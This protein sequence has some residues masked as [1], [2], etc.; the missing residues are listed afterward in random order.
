MAAVGD[1]MPW[2]NGKVPQWFL[3][4]T[5][6]ADDLLET[7]ETMD[8]WP[9]Q[10][11]LMQKNWI[12]RSRRADRVRTFRS[13]RSAS[14]YDTARYPIWGKLCAVAAN[15]PLALELAENDPALQSLLKNATGWGRAR[16]RSKPRKKG[17][18]TNVTAK[19]P[20]R[21]GHELPVYVA[22]F[23]LM[24]YGSGA[25]FGCPAH[26]QRDLDCPEVRA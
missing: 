17:F 18:R 1:R 24:E 11:L 3:R 21:D 16:R 13:Q 14:L 23:V 7:L 10:V 4:I 5:A 19:H 6:Y 8:R 12:S 2:S 20:F 26:D 15:H 25:I 9:D 22:N